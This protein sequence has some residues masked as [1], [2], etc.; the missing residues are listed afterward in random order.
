VVEQLSKQRD[1][2]EITDAQ[3]E[4]HKKRL[5]GEQAA[6]DLLDRGRARR[7]DLR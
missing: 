2:G 5:L 1:A 3:F 7:E 4:A 6:P